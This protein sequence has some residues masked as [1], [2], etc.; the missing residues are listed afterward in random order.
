M[1]S[2]FVVEDY[3]RRNNLESLGMPSY[4]ASGNHDC[5]GQKY[6]FMV[7]PRY[8][9]DLHK[10]IQE[11]PGKRLGVRAVQALSLQIVRIFTN[12][13]YQNRFFCYM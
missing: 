5:K 10:F 2:F 1:H 12:F 13:V 4:V 6:R 11:K 8:G 3:K 7:I 9:Q